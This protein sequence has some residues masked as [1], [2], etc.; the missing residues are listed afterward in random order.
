VKCREECH[1]KVVK[2]NFVKFVRVYIVDVFKQYPGAHRHF[3]SC[4]PQWSWT[5][6]V[7]E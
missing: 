4:R 2:S 6:L 1:S 7:A 3:L 5:V